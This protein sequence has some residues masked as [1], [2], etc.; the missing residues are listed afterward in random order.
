MFEIASLTLREV[1]LPLKRPFR[2][3]GGEVAARRFLLLELTDGEGHSAWSECV[4]QELPSYWPETVDTCWL[5]LKDWLAPRLMHRRVGHPARVFELLS[6]G[7]RGHRM[8]K[9]ALEMG[10]WTLAAAREGVP[11]AVLLARASGWMVETGQRPR[12]AVESGVAIGLQDDLDLLAELAQ[13]AV[14][15]GYRRIRMKIEPG[16]DVLPARAVLQAAGPNTPVIA[17]AN[18]AY[19]PDDSAHAAV[20]RELDALGLHM[21]EQPLAP[22]DHVRLAELQVRMTTPVCLDES[23]GGVADVRTM[24]RMGS[25]RAVN[26]KP[27][28]VGGLAPAIAVHDMLARVGVPVWCGGMLESGVGRAYNVALA[29]LPGFSEPGDLSPSERYW[30]RDIVRPAWA[31][32]SDGTVKVPLHS[33]GLGVEVDRDY[34]DQLTVRSATL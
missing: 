27:G 18:G 5:A 26:L 11:L 12:A 15:R 7:L 2:S 14:A 21:L 3:A 10:V 4:A 20:L 22:D 34:V 23:V 13:S 24:I 31:M 28:R 25:G 1:R 9:A 30:E 19:D 6:S 17:D 8:A 33:A 29:S 16:H 32:E